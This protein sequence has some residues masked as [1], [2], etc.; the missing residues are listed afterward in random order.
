MSD[1]EILEIHFGD[2]DQSVDPVSDEQFAPDPAPDSA[3]GDLHDL[4]DLGDSEEF[5]RRFW[6]R[7]SFRLL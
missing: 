2:P 6:C 7:F 4:G 5:R 3:L 1:E